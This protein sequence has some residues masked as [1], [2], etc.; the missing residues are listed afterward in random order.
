HLVCAIRASFHA[1]SSS[2]S[3][4]EHRYPRSFPT[5]RSSDLKRPQKQY[6]EAIRAACKEK[7]RQ[8][9]GYADQVPEKCTN[10]SSSQADFFQKGRH[11]NQCRSHAP[12]NRAADNTYV[13]VGQDKIHFELIENSPH[14]CKREGRREER[15]TGACKEAIF[16]DAISIRKRSTHK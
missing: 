4:G 11:Q 1:L 6:P 2:S 15:Y 13:G 16:L 9:Q 7:G 14:Q 10:G 12:Q 8:K 3:A 5:R